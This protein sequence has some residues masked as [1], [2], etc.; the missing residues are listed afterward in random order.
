MKRIGHEQIYNPAYSAAEKLYISIF[1]MP[2][3]GLRIRARNVFGL[4][5]AERSYTQ[6]LDAGSGPGVFSFELARRFPDAQ[7]TGIDLLAEPIAACRRIAAR[8]GVTNVEF[9]QTAIESLDGSGLYDLILC[10]DILEHIEDDQAALDHLHWL[11]ADRGILVLHVPALFRRYPV[12]RKSPNFDVASHIRTGYE[13]DTIRR[14]VESSGFRIRTCGFTYGFWETL[15]NNISYMITGARMENKVLY[16]LA[17]P[18]LNLMSLL[19][20]QARPRELGAGIFVV[21]QKN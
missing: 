16:A 14:M 1:G 8:N 3:V 9:K 15:A 5:P 20:R 19:G 10:V 7:V 18:W 21:G 12:W 4:I 6:I 11:A 17:F 2:I 13:L